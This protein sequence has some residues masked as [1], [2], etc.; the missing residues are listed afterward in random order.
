MTHSAIRSIL[1]ASDPARRSRENPRGA[2][3][4][5]G[6]ASA[7]LE[8]LKGGGWFRGYGDGAPCSITGHGT[9]EHAASANALAVLWCCTQVLDPGL[10]PRHRIHVLILYELGQRLVP[11]HRRGDQEARQG[12]LDHVGSRHA[13]LRRRVR[14]PQ[15][16]DDLVRMALQ[17]HRDQAHAGPRGASPDERQDRAFCEPECRLECSRPSRQTCRPAAAL[18]G[19][20]RMHGPLLR[21]ARDA[22]ARLVEWHNRNRPTC[23]SMGERRRRWPTPARCPRGQKSNRRAVRHRLRGGAGSERLCGS[24]TTGIRRAPQGH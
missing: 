19:P 6:G 17:G 20:P 1:K 5:T 2:S 8:Q 3:E 7:S 12:C 21:R 18:T 24:R 4:C 22:M 16:Q 13:T 9:F 11:D 10:R 15:G 23:R 14:D